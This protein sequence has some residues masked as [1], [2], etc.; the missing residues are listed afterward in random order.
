MEQECRAGEKPEVSVLIPIYN[1]ERYLAACLD[2]L[3][4]QSFADFEAICINDGSTDG[5]RAIV[6]R[7]LDADAR[8]RVIDKEN[9]GYGAS[10]NRGLDAARGR[11]VAILESDDLFEP[12]ALTL[13]HD[14]AEKNNADVAKAN[15][16]LYW[17]TPE[18]RRELFRVVDEREAGTTLRP[19]DDF[20]VFFRKPSIWSALYRRGFLV[21]NGIRFLETPGASYQDSGFNFKVWAAARRAAFIPDA[22]L[23]YRQ[24]NEQSSVNSSGKMFCVCDE[25]AEMEHFV[26]MRGGAE[27]TALLG[28][29]QRMRLDSYLWNYDRLAP[30]LRPA[31]AERAAADF[32]AALERGGLDLSL[33]EP[34]ARADL[35]ALVADPTTFCTERDAARGTLGSFKRY[36]HLGGPS[37]VA[38]VVWFRLFGR[39]RRGIDARGAAL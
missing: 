19:L 21:E 38:R 18:E 35:D 31:F 39:S 24:D 10:M 37:L 30:D 7:Y 15:F 14:A 13:L 3:V 1:V 16:N 5:S 32:R 27:E 33:F 17:S 11:Y 28:I 2:S 25:Y 22:V 8:F 36:L 34:A 26:R 23:N 20:S 6:Q 29:L 4:A 9:S 12:D